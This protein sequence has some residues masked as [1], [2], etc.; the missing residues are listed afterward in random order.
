MLTIMAKKQFQKTLILILFFGLST[1]CLASVGALTLEDAYQLALKR[2]EDV[3]IQEEQI[4]QAEE[5]LSQAK[6]GLFP[7]I[8]AVGTF[9]KQDHSASFATSPTTQNTMKLNLTQ[10]LFKGLRDFALIRQQG[11]NLD[12]V[13][14]NRDQA[15]TQLFS[16]VSQ[17]YYQ[18]LTLLEDLKILSQQK[19]VNEKRL[20]ELKDFRKIG[21]SRETDVL[22]LDANIAAQEANIEAVRVQLESAWGAFSFLTGLDNRPELN[23]REE[24]PSKLIELSEFQLNVK[25]RPDLKALESTV[26]SLDDGISVARGGHF[27][28]V[29]FL[30]NYYFDRPGVLAPVK[31]DIQLAVVFPIFQ[32]GVV[33]SQVRQASSLH[34][35]AEI[36]FEKLKRQAVQQISML[37]QQIQI[38]VSQ[39]QKQKLASDLAQKNYQAELKDSRLGLVT[40]LDVLLALSNAQDSLRLLNRIHYQI[41]IDYLKLLAYTAERPKR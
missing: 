35:Q 3:Q 16:D 14:L 33:Q 5:K 4:N 38:E 12:S 13:E 29:D 41:K 32:G 7:T 25:N 28:T 30:G 21:R 34:Q 9:L 20:S 31:W 36:Q 8:N 17:A 39:E 15:K 24:I 1:Q 2:S 26:L 11:K 37:Y 6:G 27:P 18:L 10:P 19:Q 40:N 23:D 22:A